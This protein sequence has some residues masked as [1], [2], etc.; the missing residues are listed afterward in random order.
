MSS[1]L[2]GAQHLFN[3]LLAVL[4]RPIWKKRLNSFF[5]FKQ[6]FFYLCLSLFRYN[7]AIN[8]IYKFLPLYRVLEKN[9]VHTCCGAEKEVNLGVSHGDL[10]MCQIFGT[11]ASQYWQSDYHEAKSSLYFRINS[12]SQ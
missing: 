8:T 4:P 9:K 5:S 2:F 11:F 10:A 1:L 6:L 7:V 3:S 12:L